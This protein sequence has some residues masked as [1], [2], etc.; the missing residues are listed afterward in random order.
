MTS[1]VAR[2][3]S[4]VVQHLTRSKSNAYHRSARRLRWFLTANAGHSE[5]LSARGPHRWPDHATPSASQEQVERLR[6]ASRTLL[7]AAEQI[8]WVADA[9][10]SA[11]RERIRSSQ[12]PHGTPAEDA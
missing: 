4:R 6:E 2:A 11:A 7:D 3:L 8:D 10:A 5:P 1:A 12:A 9:L